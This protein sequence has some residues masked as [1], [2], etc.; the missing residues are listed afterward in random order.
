ME[1]ACQLASNMIL[2][3]KFLKRYKTIIVAAI[4]MNMNGWKWMEAFSCMIKYL[5]CSLV[6]FQTAI[7][8]K[9]TVLLAKCPYLNSIYIIKRF[10]ICVCSSP[11]K[12]LNHQNHTAVKSFRRI[13]HFYSDQINQC[14]LGKTLNICI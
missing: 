8:Y 1:L 11:D 10:F 4:F 2:H 9:L 3:I 5:P 6:N 14:L 13:M 12:L 7:I